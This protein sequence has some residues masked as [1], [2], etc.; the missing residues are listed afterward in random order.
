MKTKQV[1]LHRA[2]A[3]L[4]LIDA[5][6]EKATSSINP[7]GFVTKGGYVNNTI[8]KELF[9]KEAKA[10]YQS[11]I[12]LIE[13]KAF[14]KTAIVNANATTT[15]EVAGNKMTI[16]EAINQKSIIEFKENLR[17]TLKSKNNA[18]DSQ[19]EVHNAKVDKNALSLAQTAL[20]K[21]N[22]ELNDTDVMSVTKPYIE[23]NQLTKVD[24][25]EIVS[26]IEVLDTDIM[27]FKTEIDAA[28][29]EINAITKIE[30]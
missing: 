25:L 10:K 20:Q 19:I 13:R 23:A 14:I 3:E 30:I 6:I 4:K 9:N 17:E 8:D 11:I 22:V 7:V 24:P 15:L 1:T 26:V 12:D 16:A 2:L 18:T 5:K 27:E 28:L 21:D 29:S